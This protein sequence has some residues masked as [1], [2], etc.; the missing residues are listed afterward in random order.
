M[1]VHQ[2]PRCELRF[3][4]ESEYNDHLRY[5][6][7]VDPARLEPFQYRAAHEQKP[8][9]PDLVEG[10]S[11]ASHRVLIV[12]NATLRAQR[13]QD[14][15]TAKAKERDTRFLLVV[16]AVETDRA[17]QPDA[18]FV[19]VGDR[20]HP[21]EHTL[22]GQVLAQH[23]LKEAMSRLRSSGL[24]IDGMVGDADPARAVAQALRDFR[25]D[26]IVVSTLPQALSN[27]LA[28]D[29]PTELRRRFSLPVTVVTAT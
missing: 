20:A 17:I 7:N 25:A 2:C 23:R 29:L 12:S 3:R 28:V 14:H 16:P 5:E 10:G 8:L 15:L 1:A 21:R 6:H 18:D 13:L 27:W 4:S 22:S 11:E 26:E 9:Y 24:E 19:T